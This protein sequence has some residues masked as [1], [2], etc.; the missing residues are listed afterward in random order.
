MQFSEYRTI[1]REGMPNISIVSDV[2]ILIEIALALYSYMLI[3]EAELHGYSVSVNSIEVAFFQVVLH[4]HI[5][6]SSPKF[7]LCKTRIAVIF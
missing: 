1:L 3:C 7:I 5:K 4:S 2:N 6:C